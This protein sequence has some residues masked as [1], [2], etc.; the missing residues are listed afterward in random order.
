[1][2]PFFG[3]VDAMP[4]RQVSLKHLFHENVLHVGYRL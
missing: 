3:Y 1:L 2:R 4:F